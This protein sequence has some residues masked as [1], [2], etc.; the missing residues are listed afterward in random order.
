M[1]RITIIL[2]GCTLV[3]AACASPGGADP[4]PDDTDAPS[5][6]DTTPP[7]DAAAANDGE[8]GDDGSTD[9]IDIDIDSGYESGV[10]V[11]LTIHD[12]DY[13]GTHEVTDEV[14][15]CNIGDTGSGVTYLDLDKPEGLYGITFISGE[16]GG[17]P[18]VFH[19]VADF[20]QPEDMFES[21]PGVELDPTGYIGNARG[22]GIA[23]LDDRGDAIAW[24]VEGTTDDDVSFE[25][26]L[27]CW[28]VGRG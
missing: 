18:G 7:P 8:D 20:D 10:T 22:S 1:K 23:R 27:L 9:G 15:D 4:S 12:G 13:A 11:Q 14:L 2:A 5:A 26:T 28:P 6:S 21:P 17:E 3:L 19:F 25:A 24:T 16:G